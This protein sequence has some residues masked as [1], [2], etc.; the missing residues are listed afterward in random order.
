MRAQ[1]MDMPQ[2]WTYVLA[3]LAEGRAFM[4]CAHYIRK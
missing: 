3:M 4:S 1:E 2:D